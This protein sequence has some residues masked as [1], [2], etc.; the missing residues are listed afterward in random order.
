MIKFSAK[1]LKYLDYIFVLRPSLFF[2][3]WIITLAGYHT[4]QHYYN[5]EATW[6]NLNFSLEILFYFTLITMASG[7]V[8]IFNQLQDVESDKQNDKC[9]LLSEKY[10][11]PKFALKY[12]LILSLLPL[13]IFLLIDLQIF[14]LLLILEL[15]WGY[16]YNYPPF[17]WKDKPLMGV[18][19]NLL[20]GFILFLIGWKMK[21]RVHT[22]AF[23]RFL[24]YMF[25]WGAVSIL[26]TIPDMQG[27]QKQTKVT[28]ALLL[29]RPTTI[30]VTLVMVIIGLIL[31]I[32]ANDPII[33]IAI[34][35]SLP[36]YIITAFKPVKA[37]VL[38]TI[39]FSV[40]FLA[41]LLVAAYPYF[42]IAL[43][44]NFYLSRIYYK[45]RFDLV[46]PSFKVQE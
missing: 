11:D 41:I 30:W 32:H 19:T 29:G 44:A 5:G 7:A 34:S 31:G 40:F 12:A 39:R 17:A 23:Y 15:L 1:I 2:A 26:T 18:L 20:A 10:I 36:F 42:L 14:I 38:R 3:V 33:Y 22:I 35:L 25:A 4:S 24:P 37:W 16:F 43:I 21:S 45:S 28:I 46:Y 6:L 13:L 27:D 9:F 8:F